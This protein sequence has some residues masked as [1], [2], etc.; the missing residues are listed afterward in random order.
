MG[1]RFIGT[2]ECD[3]HENFKKVILDAKEEDIKLFK[4]PVGYPAR[5]VK[6]HLQEMIAEETSPKIA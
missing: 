6:T 4:S 3:A 2:V 1:T 5:G